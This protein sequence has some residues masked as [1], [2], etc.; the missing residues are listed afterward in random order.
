LFEFELEILEY[1]VVQPNDLA[2]T[3]KEIVLELQ[4]EF[5]KVVLHPADPSLHSELP[6]T[7]HM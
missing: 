7:E 3:A 5:G 4:M 2:Q 1:E 6:V